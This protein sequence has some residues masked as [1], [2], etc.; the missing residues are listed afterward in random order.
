[1]LQE[2]LADSKLHAVKA[3]LERRGLSI[4]ADEAQA[5]QLAGGQQVLIPFGENA[6]LV[7]TRTNGQTAAVGLV[8]QGNK[9][10]NIS[11]TGE[12]RVVRLLPQGKVQKL[13][14]GLR[15]KSKFQEFEGKL[16][17][18]GKRVGKVRVLFDETNQIAILGIA[19]E[20]DEEKIAHQVRIK[21]KAG[22]DDEPEDD[23]EPAIQATACGQATGEAVPMGA[24]LEP[25]AL[26]PGDGGD[27]IGSSYDG[28]EGRDYGT[29]IC[30]SQWG[31]SYNCI[32][33]TPAVSLSPTDLTFP[34]TFI[35]QQTQASFTI[36]NGGGGRLTGT[37]SALAPF[38]IV[39]GGSF[40]LLPGQP[41]QVTVQFSS[42][43]A[44]SFSQN[45]TITSNAGTK[46]MPVS[47]V[48]HKVTFS[49][50]AVSFGEGMFVVTEQCGGETG[51]C[52][53]YTRKVGL[54]VQSKLVVKNEGTVAVSLN[55]STSAPFYLV[56]GGAL[57]LAAGQSAEVAVRFDPADSGTFTGTITATL[58]NGQ[59]SLTSGPLTG[60]AHKIAVSPAALNFFALVEGPAIQQ[61]L[62]ITNQGITTPVLTVITNEPFSVDASS[63]TLVAGESKDVIVQFSPTTGGEFSSTIS[64]KL[65]QIQAAFTVPVQG[66]SI[67]EAE[68]F[69]WLSERSQEG[70]VD[71]T[72]PVTS[73]LLAHLL[74]FR[75]LTPEAIQ[76]LLHLAETKDWDS[77]LPIGSLEPDQWWLREFLKLIAQFLTK[78]LPAKQSV[79]SSLKTLAKALAEGTFNA[80]YDGL[81][82]DRY[83]NEFVSKLA[84]I[85]R[86]TGATSLFGA[87]TSSEAAGV[88]IKVFCELYNNSRYG[89]VGLETIFLNFGHAGV[90][91]LAALAQIEAQEDLRNGTRVTGRVFDA[92]FIILK[93]Q[94]KPPG[95][96]DWY[97]VNEENTLWKNLATILL[98]LGED[99]A[100]RQQSVEHQKRFTATITAL[101]I[102]ASM[103]GNNWDIYAI[104][105][106]VTYSA[107]TITLDVVGSIPLG[108][109][110]RL[111]VFGQFFHAVDYRWSD[112]AALVNAVDSLARGEKLGLE[113]LRT[114]FPSPL[115]N[116]AFGAINDP[117]NIFGIFVAV[118]QDKQQEAEQIIDNGFT[119]SNYCG[120]RCF[121]VV[122]VVDENQ[123][124]TNIVIKG[125]PGSTTLELIQ[126]ALEDMG[127]KIGKKLGLVNLR[128]DVARV[129][130]IEVRI[131]AKKGDQHDET[132]LL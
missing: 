43:T 13:L 24:K 96:P 7:W 70:P 49:P 9:T 28:S 71:V 12:E 86:N 75:D 66:K 69:Q 10:L 87:A 128:A 25:L 56:S 91:A 117:R 93:T 97:Q 18:K 64:I 26:D 100:K 121:A 129:C 46:L 72:I 95:Q 110:G 112:L 8:R 54:P 14:S 124:V 76:S 50:A 17:Q 120:G 73:D 59:G 23:A 15:Q 21:V 109:G 131:Q 122:I 6:H 5:V 57:T 116:Y 35:N 36:W 106:Q 98:N 101:S 2:A 67:T 126:R 42:A 39:S 78:E 84:E 81:L 82:A 48:A 90:F 52:V 30:I 88:A 65:S 130:T 44:G 38:S 37:I 94:P 31:Y 104:R 119:N 80:T 41:Q 34:Q 105:A 63:F 85:I 33:T 108:N 68:F 62:T 125:N 20:G 4:K 115:N 123:I 79:L 83:F 92:L 60:I 102:A 32:A 29:N 19:N 118:P 89:Q 111:V 45:L 127:I 107:G 74:H 113:F 58:Q 77:L 11:V 40:S 53:P 61:R 1:L 51:E 27:L 132:H 99:A 114:L 3:Q 22:K 55:L 47:G 103:A 16:A